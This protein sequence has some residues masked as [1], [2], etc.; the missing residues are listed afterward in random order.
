MDT[1]IVA[2]SC[3]FLTLAWI[4][5]VASIVARAADAPAA[6]QAPTWDMSREIALFGGVPTEAPA[7]DAILT[8]PTLEVGRLYV[9]KLVPQTTVRFAQHPGKEKPSENSNAGLARFAVAAPGIYRIT[10]DAPAWI[11]VVSPAGLVSSS[12]FNGWHE[13]PTFRKSVQ[14]TLMASEPLVLQ[15]SG[16][17]AG[18]LRLVVTHP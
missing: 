3:T 11:D 6:C 18:T 10:V 14:Y 13:C 15:V 17:K 2:V 7:G 12:A 4:G 16:A 8:A 1:R 9:L 5:P